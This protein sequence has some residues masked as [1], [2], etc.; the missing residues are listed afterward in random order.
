MKDL[1]KYDFTPWMEET[2][3]EL[4]NFPVKGIMIA[5]VSEDSIY[6]NYYNMDMAD[7]LMMSGYIQYEVTVD[8]I[9]GKI[10]QIPEEEQEE[11]EEE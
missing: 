4:Y 3:K 7:K 1:S 9:N 2:V 6:T 8:T 5:A 11:Y 10:P